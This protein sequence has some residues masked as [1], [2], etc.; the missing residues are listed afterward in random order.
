VNTWWKVIRFLSAEFEPPRTTDSL[1][2]GQ[3][4]ILR[5]IIDDGPLTM[6]Q[7]AAI[8]GVTRATATGMVDRLMARGLVRR[9]V[10]PANRRSV[11]VRITAEGRRVQAEVHQRAMRKANQLTRHLTSAT[12]V[13][14]LRRWLT[15]IDQAV[16]IETAQR[17]Q[18]R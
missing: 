18:R 9:Y 2:I 7:V 17:E 1:S 15:A 6:T 10:N 16:E 11:R 12:G 8:A 13:S 5:G 3:L 14:E 4:R